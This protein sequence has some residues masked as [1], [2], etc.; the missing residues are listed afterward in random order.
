MCLI[1][2][3]RG[4]EVTG[5]RVTRETSGQWELTDWKYEA[6]FVFA[7]VKR[8]ALRTHLT[9]TAVPSW[10]HREDFTERLDLIEG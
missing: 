9:L 1:C 4:V 8:D 5:D 7:A 10:D 2:P 3:H 6:C